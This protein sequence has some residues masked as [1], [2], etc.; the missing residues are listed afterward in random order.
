MIIDQLTKVKQTGSGKWQ[1][2]CPA[3]EDRKPSLSVTRDN[4]KYLVHCHAGCS[5]QDVLNATGLEFKD[6]FDESVQPSRMIDKIYTYYEADGKYH[7]EVRRYLPKDFR[8]FTKLGGE[9]VAGYGNKK[10]VLY[11]LPKVVK[12]DAV[13]LV[14]G[15][16]DADR[17]M[18]EGVTATSCAGGVNGWKDYL[19]E[20]LKGKR[21][22]I[23]PDNDEAGSGFVDRV[24]PVVSKQAKKLGVLHLSNLYEKQT[25]KEFP[26]KADVYD[27][28]RELPFDVIRDAL[29]DLPTW[30]A[31]QI[32]VKEPDRFQD[33][34]MEIQVLGQ[35]LN[36]K[37]I[38]FDCRELGAEDFAVVR[39]YFEACLE[40]DEDGEEIT[41]LAVVARVRESYPNMK[42]SAEDVGAF[43]SGAAENNKPAVERLQ[44]LSARRKLKRGLD[45]AS[46]MLAKGEPASEV[47]DYLVESNRAHDREFSLRHMGDVVFESVMPI[48]DDLKEGKSRKV[49]TGFRGLDTALGGGFGMG[50]S[51]LIG[52]RTG[53]GKT[54]I[55]LQLA[56]QFT[57]LGHGAVAIHSNEMLDEENVLRIISQKSSFYN[58]NSVTKLHDDQYEVV[59][60]W[61]KTLASLP[62]YFDR[63]RT[64]RTYDS[65]ERAVR[66]SVEEY[67]LRLVIVDYIQRVPLDSKRT[68]TQTERLE[69]ISNRLA[70]LAKELKII[71]IPVTQL[72][73]TGNEAERI[74]MGGIHGAQML[75][76][77]AS[78]VLLM[79]R[80][81]MAN[82]PDEATIYIDKGRNSGVGKVQGYFFPEQL[83]FEFN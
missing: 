20:H 71:V 78:T 38:P 58:L 27:F 56:R 51:V 79:D 18:R 36:A 46:Q 11:N 32:T 23:I 21:V 76:N 42:T 29:K 13:F 33:V 61:A 83:R 19:A 2:V 6:L 55:T 1:A 16:K 12:A 37:S 82:S 48:L 77:D 65:F 24:A 17:L 80:L 73:K 67:N 64:G 81:Q 60:Q 59:T 45:R 70:N 25:G 68:L 44:V 8:P 3:H 26:K 15:E 39:P 75:S 9:T 41:P 5:V 50:D 66:A 74:T 28:L 30:S 22:I 54:A 34:E 69:I 7:S 49:S 40:L 63:Y 10:R 72:N 35:I 14:E 4:G 47:L 31:E 43:T 62:I 57:E 52:A 53:A